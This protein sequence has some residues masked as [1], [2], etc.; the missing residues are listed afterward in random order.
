[1]HTQYDEVIRAMIER[2][3]ESPAV[4]PMAVAVGENF[5]HPTVGGGN[6]G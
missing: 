3:F 6:S 2:Q 1:M 4:L 5:A